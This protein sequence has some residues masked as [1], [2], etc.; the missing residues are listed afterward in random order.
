VRGEIEAP[1]SRSG[2]RQLRQLVE[3]VFTPRDRIGSAIP[4]HEIDE[5]LL[6]SSWFRR[7]PEELARTRAAQKL[8]RRR[9]A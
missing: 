7:K 3:E 9:T 1:K 2:R 5:L 8:S 6:L 4:A